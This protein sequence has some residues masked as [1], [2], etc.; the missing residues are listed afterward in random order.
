MSPVRAYLSTGVAISCAA[1]IAVATVQPP[2]A[3]G[4]TRGVQLTAV[5]DADSPLGDG[6]ALMIGATGIPTPSQGWL[7]AYDRLY[8]EPRGF[9]GTMQAVTTPQSF[10]PVTFPFS[11]TFDKSLSQGVQ[12]VV[13]AVNAQ[14]AADEVSATNPIVI[15]GWSQGAAVAAGAMSVLADQSDP[16]PSDHLHFV[17]VGNPNTPN[18]GILERF[19]IL[20]GTTIN[21]PSLGI[22]FGNPTPSDLY[23]TDVYTMEYDGV[24]DFPQYPINFLS[25]IN[26]YL[27][28]V[29]NHL[30][31]AGLT[32]E[33]IE[34]AILLPG[35]RDLGADT[36][37]NYYMIPSD[38]LPLLAPLR[39]VPFVGNPLADLIQPALRVLVDLGYGSTTQGWSPGDADVLTPIGFL[40]PQSVLDQ[41]PEALAAGLQQGL[42]DAFNTLITPS[43]YQLI[44]PQTMTQVLDPLIG[45]LTAGANLNDPS[46]FAD[47][48]TAEL[49]GIENWFTEGFSELSFTHTGLPPV[50]MIST[51]LFTLPQIAADYFETE[52]A[53]GDPLN[54]IGVPLAAIV[55]LAPLMLIASII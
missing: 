36:L 33:Q 13:D 14:I 32:S 19:D 51:A 52:M 15:T 7:D 34:S 4:Q 12:N 42:Q 8:L 48:L 53:A 38:S 41:V 21:A 3:G 30:A 47:F 44:S 29:F 39:L 28:I 26:A 45:S 46:G 10:Y 31:Y 27:G 20:P 6:I 1:L 22:T 35:S 17:I 24:A 49:K 25:D 43:N 16:V 9:T 5:D 2:V 18:G 40:P 54:A 37:T 50:D 23:P 11:M 55:G